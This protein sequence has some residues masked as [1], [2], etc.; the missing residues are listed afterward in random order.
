MTALPHISAQ[1]RASV[2]AA[3][4]TALKHVS[5]L[6]V[7]GGVLAQVRPASL[8]D[9]S[10]PSSLELFL[11]LANCTL[12]NYEG[13]ILQAWLPDEQLRLHTKVSMSLP[14]T[15]RL[16]IIR[17]SIVVSTSHKCCWL[18]GCGLHAGFTLLFDRYVYNEAI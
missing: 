13:L 4:T 1:E 18:T 2:L 5:S 9:C 17:L 8:T 10:K 7:D 6:Q 15:Q 11:L 3:L 14:C 12:S 16:F